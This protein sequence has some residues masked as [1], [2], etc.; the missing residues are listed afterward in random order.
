MSGHTLT[1]RIKLVVPDE[2]GYGTARD[3]F[4][5]LSAV[6]EDQAIFQLNETGY[7]DE[8]S[9][10]FQVRYETP[11]YTHSEF[12]Q[13]TSLSA[14]ERAMV[15]VAPDSFERRITTADGRT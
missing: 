15:A 11:L 3:A 6:H 1:L 8:D 7:V 14:V 9:W 5:E 10:G 4:A 2:D 13:S 12:V